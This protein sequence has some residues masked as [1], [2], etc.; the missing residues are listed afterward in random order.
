MNIIESNLNLS[1]K[2]YIKSDFVIMPSVDE[3][4]LAI[5]KNGK[6]HV[7]C[8]IYQYTDLAN[9][10]RYTVYEPKTSF[11]E[12][13]SNNSAKPRITEKGNSDIRLNNFLRNSEN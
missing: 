2:A 10:T 3:N 5:V 11:I 9:N 13:S 12:V 7:W 4:A 1:T 8:D 6:T